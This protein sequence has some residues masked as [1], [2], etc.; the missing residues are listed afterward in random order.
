MAINQTVAMAVRT[1]K[2]R[3]VRPGR[4]GRRDCE[5]DIG[6]AFAPTRDAGLLPRSETPVAVVYGRRD[7]WSIYP[8]TSASVQTATRRLPQGRPCHYHSCL[9]SVIVETGNLKPD[10]GCGV[11][12]N[13]HCRL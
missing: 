1:P 6:G 12:D 7:L 5:I 4:T 11:Q 3:P 10:C 9:P 13:A 8:V 2:G